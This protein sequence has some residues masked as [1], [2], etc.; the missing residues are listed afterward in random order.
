MNV[1]KNKI[2]LYFV[3]TLCNRD[4]LLLGYLHS[5]SGSGQI[6]PPTCSLS[7]NNFHSVKYTQMIKH[8]C[9]FE[10]VAKALGSYSWHSR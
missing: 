9:I 6:I 10:T 5:V 7:S 1:I 8:Y 3:P 4:T 2:W